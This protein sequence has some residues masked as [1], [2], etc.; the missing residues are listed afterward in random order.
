MAYADA[1]NTGHNP[2]ATPPT[3]GVELA[4]QRPL[5]NAQT[6]AIANGAGVW[7]GRMGGQLATYEAGSETLGTSEET[8]YGTEYAPTVVDGRL[9]HAL[10]SLVY[11]DVVYARELDGASE[12]DW[13]V[14][15]EENVL[16][17]PTLHD[18]RL[19]VPERGVTAL[20]ATN[21]DQTWTY[22]TENMTWTVPAVADGT[23]YLLTSPTRGPGTLHAV[24]V[25]SGEASWTTEVGP[26]AKSPPV[27]AAG[28]VFVVLAADPAYDDGNRVRAYDVATGEESWTFEIGSTYDDIVAPPA[29]ADGTV[30]LGTTGETVALTAASGEVEWRS[31]QSATTQPAVGNGVLYVC[32]GRSVTALDASDGSRR[33]EAALALVGRPSLSVA[34]DRVFVAGD[35]VAALESG[36]ATEVREYGDGLQRRWQ[37]E[38]GSGYGEKHATAANGT[39]YHASDDGTFAV[40]ADG[41]ASWASDVA[42]VAPPRVGDGTVFVSTESALVA[43]DAASGEREWSVEVEGELVSAPVVG[44]DGVYV[45]TKGGPGS[46]GGIVYALATEDGS[47]RWEHELEKQVVSA[48]GVGDG[49]VAATS[50][51]GH[52][53]VVVAIDAASGERLWEATE[54]PASKSSPLVDDDRVYVNARDLMAF[55]AASGETQWNAEL[56][57][58]GWSRPVLVEGMLYATTAGEHASDES[59]SVYGVNAA[60][61]EVTLDVSTG[62]SIAASPAIIGWT[63]YVGNVLGTVYAIEARSGDLLGWR[64]LGDSV[65]STTAVDETLCVAMDDSALAALSAS[66]TVTDPLVVETVVGDEET[67]STD[68]GGGGTTSATDDG[69]T[70]GNGDG[71]DGADVSSGS[72]NGSESGGEGSTPGF[73]VVGALAALGVGAGLRRRRGGDGSP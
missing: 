70:V 4:Y 40:A 15:F 41:T 45:G 18:G 7:F 34:G 25:T 52:D 20:D 73:G 57:G 65:R 47:T 8:Q 39:V 3:D 22:E 56:G 59:G 67:T 10:H 51:E 19:Y 66:K 24:D 30:Y 26:L 44:A 29:V 61:G 72:S 53:D 50:G 63:V 6:G 64:D 12:T 54:D 43:L 28:H 48:P 37:A 32:G 23:A 14:E 35:V 11:T 71:G 42:A 17:P 68:G 58:E 16:A 21:G 46:A 1:A 9:Y 38:R 2:D 55:D 33:F 60:T 62:G 31:E 49:V 36:G 69:T 13:E 27:V 5:A